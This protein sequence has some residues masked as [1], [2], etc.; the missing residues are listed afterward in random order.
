MEVKF[1]GAFVSAEIHLTEYPGTDF[2]SD[3][4]ATGAVITA[5]DVN[6]RD[7][8]LCRRVVT[9]Y[10]LTLKGTLAQLGA[11]INLAERFH[12]NQLIEK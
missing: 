12:L 8:A 1:L 3:L 9:S 2:F 4:R 6:T 5:W 10:V 7:D 11:A